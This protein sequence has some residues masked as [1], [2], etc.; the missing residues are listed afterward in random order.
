MTRRVNVPGLGRGEFVLQL[1]NLEWGIAERIGLYSP[2]I[3]PPTNGELLQSFLKFG[4]V[5]QIEAPDG[6]MWRLLTLDWNRIPNHVKILC[7][8]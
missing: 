4:H 2:H 1:C 7:L 3:I 6:S 5:N 8:K